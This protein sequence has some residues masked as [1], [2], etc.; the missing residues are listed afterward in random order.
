MPEVQAERLARVGGH[1][2]SPSVVRLYPKDS[3][4]IQLEQG[5]RVSNRLS[6]SERNGRRKS[7]SRGS[8]QK[9]EL[10]A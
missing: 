7:V 1:E 3:A 8:P 10:E 4:K 9:A 2:L 5:S 6:Q